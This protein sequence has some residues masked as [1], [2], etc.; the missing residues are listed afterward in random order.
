MYYFVNLPW[1]FWDIS[2]LTLNLDQGLRSHVYL[3]MLP[4]TNHI[5]CFN[6]NDIT[7]REKPKNKPD[8][9][10]KCIIPS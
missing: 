5:A 1:Y 9:D 3:S 4:I 2:K 10:Q 6:Q 8:N 7:S